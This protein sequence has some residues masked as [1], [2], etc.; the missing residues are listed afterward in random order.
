MDEF[1]STRVKRKAAKRI[2]T[3]AMRFISRNRTAFRC[4]VCAYLIFF[5]G[6][7]VEFEKRMRRPPLYDAVA[8]A[9]FDRFK[10]RLSAGKIQ[11]FHVSRFI[12][13][14]SFYPVCFIGGLIVRF[15]NEADIVRVVRKRRVDDAEIG[16]RR[17]FR[18]FGNGAIYPLADD[19]LPRVH[20]RTLYLLAQRKEHDAGRVAVETMYDE[21]TMPLR[22]RTL[23]PHDAA[24]HVERRP[25]F[26]ARIRNGKHARRFMYDNDVR[27]FIEDIDSLASEIDFMFALVLCARLF[28]TAVFR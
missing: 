15:R 22:I 3:S 19:F 1:D 9:R 13:I 25:S 8:R 11:M 20:E 10:L 28:H 27:V 18:I 17:P 6:I 23:A 4:K 7:E 16:K 24:E 2:G 12:F 14:K 26:A 21:G 5:T